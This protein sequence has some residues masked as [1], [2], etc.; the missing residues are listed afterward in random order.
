MR[1]E[2]YIAAIVNIIEMNKTVS[3]ALSQLLGA[4]KGEAFRE[5]K[6][7]HLHRTLTTS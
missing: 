6:K 7:V 1:T 2:D 4:Y 3:L 5:Q